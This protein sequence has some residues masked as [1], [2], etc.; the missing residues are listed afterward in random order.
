MLFNRLSKKSGGEVDVDK[1]DGGK[2]CVEDA[3][4]G[5]KCE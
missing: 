2:M 4:V 1:V 3:S 5:G